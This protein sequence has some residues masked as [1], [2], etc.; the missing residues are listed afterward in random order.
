MVSGER[1]NTVTSNSH[2]VV[3]PPK[4]S[5]TACVIPCVTLSV[6]EGLVPDLSGKWTEGRIKWGFFYFLAI[7]QPLLS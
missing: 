2:Y 4:G 3:S 6:L 5:G 1:L 7:A